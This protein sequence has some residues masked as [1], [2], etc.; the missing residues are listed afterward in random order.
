MRTQAEFFDRSILKLMFS[1]STSASFSSIHF[2]T[3][4]LLSLFYCKC[5]YLN[6]DHFESSR[7]ESNRI[8]PTILICPQYRTLN[9]Y[10]AKKEKVD[11]TYIHLKFITS[12]KLH[13]H[14]ADVLKLKHSEHFGIQ[15]TFENNSSLSPTYLPSPYENYEIIK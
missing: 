5:F 14:R 4:L 1:F 8:E 7:I 9:S 15:S 2:I 6:R 12:I 3:V 10:S 11:K 13:A